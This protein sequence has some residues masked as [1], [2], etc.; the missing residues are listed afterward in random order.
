MKRNVIV[1]TVLTGILT[2][3]TLLPAEAQDLNQGQ[4]AQNP[5]ASGQAT[6]NPPASG[7]ATQN[8]P[9]SGQAKPAT[10]PGQAAP[11]GPPAP[12]PDERNAYNAIQH[13]LDPAR[14]AQ[15]VDD[16][17]KKYPSS[18]L[19]SD[20]YFFGAYSY[21]SQNNVAKAVEYGE[22]SLEANGNNLR[23]LLLLAGLLPQPQEMQ[24]SDA[25]K[26]KKLDEAE[27]DASKALA[28]IA[29]LNLPNMPPDQASQIKAS[30]T[31]QAHASLGMVHLQRATMSLAGTD[32]QELGKA[33]TEYKTAVTTPKPT[34]E[35]YFRLGE[36]YAME[37]KYDDGIDAF[38]QCSKLSQGGPLQSMADG[39]TEKL[40]KAKAQAPPPAA[41][42]P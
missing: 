28:Q 5:P 39:E 36:V 1:V 21:Q 22:K 34:A 35:D 30:I 25:D 15:L 11:A 27:G 13:E 29:T 4:A 9:A 37:N 20:V 32:P 18:S 6:Q 31:S 24:G 7:Q 19:L 14:Q 2:A 16:F 38:T 41:A 12:T 26:A 33:E 17:A 10:Q 40:K 42:K 8:P 23:S 3:L